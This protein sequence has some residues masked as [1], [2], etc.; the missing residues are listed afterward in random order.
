MSPLQRQ[1]QA[2]RFNII[3]MI[4]VKMRKR[5]INKT[6]PL[7]ACQVQCPIPHIRVSSSLLPSSCDS[8]TAGGADR[9]RPSCLHSNRQTVWLHPCGSY[10]PVNRAGTGSILWSQPKLGPTEK[11]LHHLSQSVVSAL[12]LQKFKIVK[13]TY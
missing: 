13:F 11:I 4:G 3:N 8:S 1:G 12:Y 7:S 5:R 2:H 10:G 6:L 9:A